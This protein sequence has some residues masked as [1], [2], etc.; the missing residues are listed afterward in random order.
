M[1]RKTYTVLVVPRGRAKLRKFSIT[2]RVVVGGAVALIAL[3]VALVAVSVLYLTRPVTTAQLHA[4]ETENRQLRATNEDLEA[5]L[6]VLSSRLAEFERRSRKLAIVA[7]IEETPGESGVGGQLVHDS[8]QRGPDEPKLETRLD[9]LSGTLDR[10]RETLDERV[11]WTSSIPSIRPTAGILTSRFGSRRDPITGGRGL[12]QGIDI[13]APHGEPVVATADGLVVRAGSSDELGKSVQL[14]HGFGLVTRY[15]HM[16]RLTVRPG[17]RVVRGETI[18]YVGS[19]GRSTGTHLHY[20][21]FEDGEPV[22]PIA[23]LTP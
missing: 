9:E 4:V 19:T 13:S 10:V 21:V 1:Q 18:G 14:S 11:A 16:S 23:H 3:L 8:H 7:G 12:H 22:D 15:G 2:R 17:D 6:G 20:E 5:D